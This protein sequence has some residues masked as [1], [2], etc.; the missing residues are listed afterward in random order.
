[1]TTNITVLLTTGHHVRIRRVEDLPP[2][3]ATTAGAAK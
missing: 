1:M 3:V 2:R